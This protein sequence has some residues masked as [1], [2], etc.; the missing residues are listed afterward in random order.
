MEH[1]AVGALLGA[2]IIW[3]IVVPHF[4]TAERITASAALLA[5]VLLVA[6]TGQWLWSG[7]FVICVVGLV[8]VRVQQVLFALGGDK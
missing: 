7:A 4:L 3:A 1:S 2:L 8:C 6:L 5:S